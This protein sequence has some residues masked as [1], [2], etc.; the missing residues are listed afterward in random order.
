MPFR[1]K[2]KPNRAADM[3]L[4]Q[5]QS[6]QDTAVEFR[7]R[8]WRDFATIPTWVDPDTVG[9]DQ[10]FTAPTVAEQCYREMIAFL[11]KREKPGA[12]F[13]LIEPSAGA[14]VFYDLMPPGHRTGLDIMP[15][16]RDIARADFLTW[17]PPVQRGPIAVIGNPPFGYRAWLAL[18]F[19]NHAATFADHI[20]MILPMAF[21]S[22]GKG[23]PKHRVRGMTLKSQRVLPANSFEDAAGRP[24]KVNALWQIWSKGENTSAH[25]PAVGQSVDLFTVDERKERLCGQTRMA[26]A[27]YFLQR[28]FY[29]DPP[30]LVRSFREV[31][32]VCGYGIVIKRRKDEI[33]N[34]L[35]A[36]DWRGYS[37][38]AA[39][40]CRH[41]SMYHIQHAL[42]DGGYGDR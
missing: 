21:Q 25:R 9:L 37:N 16:R 23:S 13:H 28:T 29:R 10:F 31:R 19:M 2:P 14:G 30:T 32:Y 39:H 35:K 40:N 22:D 42:A 41:I 26:E 12:P 5:S 8:R 4:P 6:A 7:N 34:Y 27:D 11:G 15:L 20:G 36:V 38:L 1:N 3:Y 24:V 18:E 17:A 33:S